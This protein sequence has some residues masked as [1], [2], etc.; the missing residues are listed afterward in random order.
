MHVR[1]PCNIRYHRL[2]STGRQHQ[3]FLLL[4]SPR[5]PALRPRNNRYPIHHTLISSGAKHYACTR[6]NSDAGHLR[7]RRPLSDAYRGYKTG[8][9]NIRATTIERFNDGYAPETLNSYE[10]GMKS[11]LLENRLRAN[12]AL[13]QSDYKDIQT[14][15]QVDP[16]NPAATDVFNA[17]KARI[18]GAELDLTARPT[19]ALTVG[20]SYAYLDAKFLQILDQGGADIT[21]RYTYVE[22]PKHTI[23][24][25]MEYV[26]PETFIGRPSI[27]IDYY[28]QSKKHTASGDPR[29]IIG[30][31]GL[32][33]ARLS[34]S[35]IPIG[36]GSF[37]ISAFGK[38]LTDTSYYVAHYQGF[39][40]AAIFGEPRTYGLELSLNF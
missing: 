5:P 3:R 30:D 7:T 27:Y 18:K 16:L 1:C 37:K 20:L 22:A 17:G 15:V 34:L 21:S 24:T 31:Y 13:F 2:G 26:F 9:Y 14:N 10:L 12:L 29:F 11:S 25:N 32:L 33:N 36:F 4:R 40:P 38:N 19:Q 28:M 8:G 6:A 39:V 35:D 23:S